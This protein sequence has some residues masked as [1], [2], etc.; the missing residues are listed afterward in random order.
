MPGSCT[1]RGEQLAQL[2]ANLVADAIRTV[3]PGHYRRYSTSAPR[4]QPRLDAFDL[5]E[6]PRSAI[7]STMSR[8]RD[9]DDAE[10]GALPE[11]LMRDLGDGDVELPQPILHPP[12]HHALVLQRLRIGQVELDASSRRP[13]IMCRTA[14]AVC[15]TRSIVNTSMTSPTLMSLKCSR[16]MPHSKPGLH[17]AHVVLEAAQRAEL[18][19]VDHDVVAQQPRLRVAGARDA[20]VGDHA[21]GDGADLRHLEDLAHFGRCRCRTSLNVGSSRPAIAFFISSVTL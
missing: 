2:L 12:Q 21:A 16:P 10:P 20:A 3:I 5:V 17:L 9:G 18:A 8:R 15:A 11:I 4:D 14:Y 13:P 1:S 19:F 7:S 6:R